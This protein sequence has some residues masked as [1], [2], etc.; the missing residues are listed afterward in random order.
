M[1][2]SLIP[3]DT[4]KLIGEAVGSVLSDEVV[5]A[6]ANEVEYRMREILQVRLNKF[7]II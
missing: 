5:V 7:L 6:L 2:S 1:D 4:I 3:K